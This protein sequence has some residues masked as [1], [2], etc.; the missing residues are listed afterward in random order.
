MAG[1]EPR[2]SCVSSDLS[3]ILDTT[4]ARVNSCK[5]TCLV[6]ASKS[7]FKEDNKSNSSSCGPKC[8][9]IVEIWR[10]FEIIY[11]EKHQDRCHE[12]AGIRTHKLQ[13]VKQLF[14]FFH[15]FTFAINPLS[16]RYRDSNSQLLDL[17][18]ISLLLLLQQ[19][20]HWTSVTRLGDFSKFLA[21]KIL[22]K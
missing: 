22:Q 18:I 14:L 5:L 19:L 12:W 2:T 17:L 20:D 21:K 15:F 13:S 10:L 4:T 3:T 16:I 1:F 11:D 8:V 9:S 6:V 7:L